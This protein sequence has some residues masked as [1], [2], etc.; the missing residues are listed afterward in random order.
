MIGDKN[1]KD[2]ALGYE[3][4]SYKDLSTEEKA[5]IPDRFTKAIDDF[6]S[7][8]KVA[9]KALKENSAALKAN[10]EKAKDDNRSMMTD[11]QFSD[12]LFGKGSTNHDDAYITKLRKI[13]VTAGMVLSDPA[14]KRDVATLS[15]ELTKPVVATVSAT[16]IV[17]PT[18]P[19]P[20]VTTPTVTYTYKAA[21]DET[22]LQVIVKAT[23]SGS[24]GNK[25]VT[26]LTVFTDSASAYQ[27]VTGAATVRKVYIK[28]GKH[29]YK[30]DDETQ[31]VQD[32]A[33]IFTR[34]YGVMHKGKDVIAALL[35]GGTGIVKGRLQADL[36]V[37]TRTGGP[38]AR[39]PE[40]YKVQN[41][42]KN[43]L[44]DK[45][46]G[47][48]LSLREMLHVHQELGSGP[49]Q[50]GVCLTSISLSERQAQGS[51]WEGKLKT[52]YANNGIPF[53]SAKT[54]LVLVDFAKVP[55]GH[56]L[57]YN[58]YRPDAQAQAEDAK[59]QKKFG[60]KLVTFDD[61][62]HMLDS[63]SKN[64]EVFLRVLLREY[65]ANWPDVEREVK[66]PTTTS[67]PLT[68]TASIGGSGGGTRTI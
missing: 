38:L 16:P 18:L 3:V 2:I 27:E 35:D 29:D 53:K 34:R 41:S 46:L 14:L 9:I 61:N 45:D 63:V 42:D 15:S 12:Y 36:N 30:G 19:T 64:R 6:A 44:Q 40:I 60:R 54:V 56:D 67:P 33:D 43:R 37:V 21:I 8:A 13:G 10:L 7:S 47:D 1:S 31:Y 20:V 4:R 22:K 65:I 68:A 52:V 48:A 5:I 26:L 39:D 57:L 11:S 55:T 28:K 25:D 50:R 58:L 17:T 66:P 23:G 62:Q 24:S 49:S 32:D 59:M 51:G